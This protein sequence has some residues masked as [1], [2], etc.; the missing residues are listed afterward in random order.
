MFSAVLELEPEES[1][2][3]HIYIYC[4]VYVLFMFDRQCKIYSQWKQAG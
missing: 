3:S 1:S 2:V 4:A